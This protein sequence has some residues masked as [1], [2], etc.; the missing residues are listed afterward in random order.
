M[1]LLYSHSMPPRSKLPSPRSRDSLSVEVGGWF[2][3]HATGG[4]VVAIP[5]VI[6]LLV[7]AIVAQHFLP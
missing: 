1:Y 7:A 4:G 6:L 3:A 2:K 5:L